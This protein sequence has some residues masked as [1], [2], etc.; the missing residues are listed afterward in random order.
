VFDPSTVD[1]IAKLSAT[2]LLALGFLL[3]YL[4]KLRRESEV[5]EIR[6]DRDEWKNIA[7]SALAKLD[8]LTD[9]VE[10][11]SGKKIPD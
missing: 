1:A 4:G 11:L 3:L 8:R 2:G 9:V 10:A 6:S 7:K 5:V